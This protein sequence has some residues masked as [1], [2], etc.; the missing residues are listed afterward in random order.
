[1]PLFLI[2][3]SHQFAVN[4]HGLVLIHIPHHE[5][6]ETRNLRRIQGLHFPRIGLGEVR[7]FIALDHVAR[8]KVLQRVRTDQNRH[9][10]IG[11]AEIMVMHVLVEHDLTGTQEQCR[12]RLR[13]NR[14]PVVGTIRRRVVLRRDHDHPRSTL[15][16]FEFPVRFRHLVFDE[17]LTPAC[18]Q[19]RE[20]HVAHVDVRGLHPGPERMPWVLVTVPGVVRPIPAALGL[21]GLHFP[22]VVVE[23]R[24]AATVHPGDAHFADHAQNGHPRA[25]LHGPHAGTLGHLDHFRRIALLPQPTGTGF[26]AVPLRDN[27]HGFGQVRKRRI[28]AH[29]QHV[30]QVPRS[31]FE[32]IHDV[33]S[34]FRAPG[35]HPG[36]PTT[37]HQGAFQPIGPIHPTM[38]RVPLQAHPRIVRKRS[39][40]AVEVFV[41]LVVVVLLDPHDHTVT[42]EGTHAAGVSVVRGADPRKRRIIAILIVVHPLPGAIRILAQRVAHFDNR[43]QRSQGQG[44]VR[45]RHCRDRPG[46]HF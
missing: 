29:P 3:P 22:D 2:V 18:V 42:H 37:A 34:E 26:A 28:P 39:A 27:D 10:R 6:A 7:Q 12:V 15:D 43:L 14:N 44:F 4:R 11:R 33:R 20:P 1:M 13:P 35:I 23:Q 17:V 45:Q 16:T 46:G 19:L 24:A 5:T 32:L 21:V 9:V 41:G 8:I 30:I 38:H 31:E 40:V 36:F 25:E